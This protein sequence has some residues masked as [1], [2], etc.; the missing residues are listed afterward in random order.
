MQIVIVLLI[1][2][3]LRIFVSTA[4]YSGDLNNHVGWGESNLKYGYEGAYDRQYVGIMQ[5]TYPPIAIGAF[6]ASVGLYETVYKISY[7]LNEKIN[8]FPSKIIWSL[9]D[10]NVRPAF[11]KI[12]AIISDV[13]VG[14][15]IYRFCKSICKKSRKTSVIVAAAYLFNPAVWYISALWGQIESLPIFFILLSIWMAYQKKYKLANVSFVAAVLSKQTSL[16]FSPLFLILS[17]KKFGIKK[18]VKGLFIQMAIFYIAYLPFAPTL[19]PLWPFQV[20][21]NRIQTGSGSVWIT[22]HAFNVWIWFSHLQKIPDTTKVIG[23]I[24][25]NIVGIGLFFIAVLAPLFAYTKRKLSFNQ[26]ILL[27]SLMPMAAF[28]FLTKMHER[29]SAPAIPFIALASSF[30]PVLWIIYF[31]ES[32][33]HLVN[34]YHEWYFPRIGGVDT[35]VSDWTTIQV[36]AITNIIVTLILIWKNLKPKA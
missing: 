23:Q 22:D 1:S 24:S 3:L 18:T 34:L 32:V 21:I 31:L 4:I 15:L 25:A 13:G 12:I 28:S 19:S 36:C 10:E 8:L 27:C 29:Y 9:Q 30:D 5:P 11:T 14:L 35:L 2:L 26:L 6:T 17:Y 33:A 7:S 16:I 20:Y